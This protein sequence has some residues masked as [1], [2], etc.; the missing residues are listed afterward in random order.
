MNQK[1]TSC[2]CDG[3]WTFNTERKMIMEYK[4][5]PL[6]M[7]FYRATKD[8]RCCRGLCSWWSEKNRCC[9]VPVL[10]ELANAATD[11]GSN[12][13]RIQTKEGT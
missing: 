9:S 8:W 3:G 2:L 1:A 10:A 6:M 11:R 4:I 5:C 13:P 12:L 7:A